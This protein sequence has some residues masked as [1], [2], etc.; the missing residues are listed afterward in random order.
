MQVKQDR[1][2][3]LWYGRSSNLGAK[4]EKPPTIIVLHYTTGWNGKASRNWLM[5]EAG[6]TSNRSSSAHIVIDRD[7]TSWQIAEFT[8][9]A[10]HAGPSRYG[11]IEGV[12]AHSIGIEFVNAGWLK[13]NGHGDFV[14]TY[15]KRFTDRDLR[16]TGGY[17]KAAHSRVGNGEYA[18]PLFPEAQLDAG[19]E[20]VQALLA[21]YPIAAIVTH[22]EIDTRG[23]KTDPGPAFPVERFRALLGEA[24]D[25]EPPHLVTA[26]RLNLRGGPG[27]GFEKIIPPGIL[28]KDTRVRVLAREGGWAYVVLE[29]VHGETGGLRGWVYSSYIAPVLHS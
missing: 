29:N 4:R 16:R 12:N 14:D 11:T 28:L 8:R 10:W 17:V 9:T 18:W 6:G 15:G 27:T 26:T 20:I 7:G 25:R 24:A 1:I 19:A 3:S 2:A 23:W 13:P 5:G 21:A 22:E